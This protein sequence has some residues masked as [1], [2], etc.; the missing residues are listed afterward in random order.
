MPQLLARMDDS[1]W[2][3]PAMAEMLNPLPPLPYDDSFVN[4]QAKALEETIAAGGLRLR[5]IGHARLPSHTLFAVQARMTGR[6]GNR[7]QASV[8]D[9]KAMLPQIAQRL[10]A[11]AI[12]V[13]APLEGAPG[14]MGVLVR[15]ARHRPLTLRTLLMQPSFQQFDQSLCLVLGLDLKQA[16]VVRSLLDVAHLLVLGTASSRLH[17]LHSVL[18]TL[19]LF[20]TPS[21]LQLMLVGKEAHVFGPF[22]DSPHLVEHPLSGLEGARQAMER[23]AGEMDQR[24][25]RFEEKGVAD[26]AA[27]NAWAATSSAETALPRVL[28]ILDSVL[29]GDQ[30]SLLTRLV[31]GGPRAGLH[32]IVVCESTAALPPETVELFR[33]RLVLRGAAADLKGL[34][35]QGVPMRFADALLLEGQ[36]ALTPLEQCVVAADEIAAVVGYWT[37][38]ANQRAGVPEPAP[39]FEEAMPVAPDGD[40]FAEPDIFIPLEVGA[41]PPPP[42]AGTAQNMEMVLRRARALAAYLGWLSVGPLRDILDLSES[43]ARS[44]MDQLKA[45]GLLEPKMAPTLRYQRLGEP[46][47]G[48]M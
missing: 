13:M 45:E 39:T 36:R 27:Y 25:A 16:V 6:L 21:E 41:E 7:R 48:E 24:L 1:G 12:D 37:R 34:P 15:N 8:E 31:Q 40:P 11:E 46:P 35:L 19:M 44:V 18:V 29:C 20:N 4:A 22:S 42:L 17:F 32:L 38:S 33:A 5:V 28:L 47:G 26:L 14:A 30:A 3:T 10:E 43:Q 9:V 23:L 2:L